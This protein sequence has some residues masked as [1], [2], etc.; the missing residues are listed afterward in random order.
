MY[1]TFVDIHETKENLTST[2]T[3]LPSDPVLLPV[4]TYLIRM[5][6]RALYVYNRYMCWTHAIVWIVMICSCGF[7]IFGTCQLQGVLAG[8]IIPLSDLC[9]IWHL[10]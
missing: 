6:Q 8:V 5:Q 1:T 9:F 4:T 10:L 3:H 2:V 7:L